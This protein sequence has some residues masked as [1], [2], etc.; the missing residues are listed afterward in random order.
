MGQASGGAEGLQG[1]AGSQRSCGQECRHH[2][3][4]E[5]GGLVTVLIRRLRRGS[6]ARRIEVRHQ[7]HASVPPCVAVW[8]VAL[9]MCPWP[10]FAQG[11]S[12][13]TARPLH[14]Q[15]HSHEAVRVLRQA[16]KAHPQSAEAHLLLGR[17]LMWEGQGWESI[18][19][20][21]EAVQLRPDSAKTQGA[22]GKALSYFGN[23]Q[24]ARQPLERALAIDPNYAPAQVSL[25]LVLVESA[26][27]SPALGHLSRAIRLLGNSSK[28][29]YPHYLRARAY[30]ELK[31]FKSAE[32]DLNRAVSLAPDFSE[33]WS[34][35][36]EARK[37]LYDNT[38]A[39]AAFERAVQLAPKDPVAQTRLGSELLD[40]GKAQEALPHLREATR[41]DPQSQAA[42]WSLQRALSQDGH[43][44]Q[45]EAVRKTLAALMRKK[46]QDS[47]NALAAIELN[48]QGAV[49][50]KAG[51]L[52]GA[53]EKYRQALKLDPKHIGIRLNYAAALLHLGR[54]NEGVA[55]L[56][57]IIREDPNNIEAQ[58]ALHYVLAHPL[59]GQR[60][61]PSVPADG[62]GAHR[63][64]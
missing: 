49:L 35:L 34:D 47:R 19:Q 3:V 55:E 36:G 32:A 8:T 30:T 46:Q 45:A 59:P 6:T 25:G 50:Q 41:L 22:L 24:A 5:D 38:G 12:V 18:E 40:Q 2:K 39:L 62:N 64:D 56:R 16:V 48:N 29:A 11:S 58:Q 61:Q 54:W 10:A 43:P 52:Q 23:N 14:A 13:E 63:P 51:N 9:M 20:L 15:G 7:F 31:Q 17:E 21:R 33:A 42:L 1:F 26:E 57:E 37:A 53:M 27:Y 60:Q 44:K 28:A 4:A